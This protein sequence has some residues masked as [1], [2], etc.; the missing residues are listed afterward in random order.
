MNEHER[1]ELEPPAA[2]LRRGASGPKVN[3]TQEWLCLHGHHT[4]IDGDFGPATEAALRAWQRQNYA[5]SREP[6]PLGTVDLTTWHALTEP[7]RRVVEWERGADFANPVVDCAHAHLAANPREVGGPNHG[8]WVRLYMDGNE[9]PEFPWCAGFATYVL[10]Q[11]L[12]ERGAQ[13]RTFSCDRLAEM[14]Q[15]RALWLYGFGIVAGTEPRRPRPGDLFLLRRAST[16]WNHTGIVTR[17]GPDHFETIEGNT[18][19]DGS[20]EGNAVHERVRAFNRVD[21][22]LMGET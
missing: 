9:G 3:Q 14:A 7:M 17:V 16:D 5:D 13:W 22:V 19:V 6:L 1:R 10:M 20:R 11:A 21:F 4:A 12:V 2:P 8:P 15:E 18:N